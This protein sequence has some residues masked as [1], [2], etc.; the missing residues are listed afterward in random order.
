MLNAEVYSQNSVTINGAGQEASRLAS[1]IMQPVQLGAHRKNISNVMSNSVVTPNKSQT[2]TPDRA[3]S[4]LNKSA[5]RIAD[6]IAQGTTLRG[7]SVRV[8]NLTPV[9]Q[10]TASGYTPQRQ[11]HYAGT[12]ER[13]RT[14]CANI[15]QPIDRASESLEKINEVFRQISVGTFDQVSYL[16]KP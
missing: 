12:F 13:T 10:H 15:T 9:R 7:N 5:S 8:S 2:R 11:N 1:K 3:Q 16:R 4:N 14:S 6:H